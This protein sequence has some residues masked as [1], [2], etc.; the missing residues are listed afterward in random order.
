[1]SAVHLLD[2][3]VLL[4]LSWPTHLHFEASHRFFDAVQR[5]ATTPITEL[6]FV[7]LS[8]NPAV[9]GDDAVSTAEARQVLGRFIGGRGGHVFWPDT[10]STVGPDDRE[11]V[12]PDPMTHRQVT[13]AHLLRLAHRHS[14]SVATFDRALRD[15]AGA[16]AKDLV[17]LIPHGR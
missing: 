1:V 11:R 15:L 10:H 5:W 6:G 3:N 7:R 2:V 14:G 13:D 16:D 4:A 9:F 12:T 8:S 17:T